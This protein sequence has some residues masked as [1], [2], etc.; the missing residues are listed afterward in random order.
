M[1]TVIGLTSCF[2]CVDAESS[3][4][5]GNLCQHGTSQQRTV[6]ICASGVLP[7]FRKHIGT[8]INGQRNCSASRSLSTNYRK[9][10]RGACDAR[11]C[12]E[13]P[14]S[15]Q[16]A[17]CVHGRPK[18]DHSNSHVQPLWAGCRCEPRSSKASRTS[19]LACACPVTLSGAP[20]ET[21]RV[22]GL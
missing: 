4:L 15:R 12:E 1:P 10:E 3:T 20:Q 5:N 6:S 22:L 2:N 11:I 19:D 13:V 16:Q 18:K 14:C 21:S 7:G 17:T 9:R 8:K